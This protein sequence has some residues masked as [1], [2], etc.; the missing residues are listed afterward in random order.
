MVAFGFDELG[1]HRLV[2][3]VH[4]DNLASLRVLMRVGMQREGVL[5]QDALIEGEWWD[6]VYCSLLAS[7]RQ[8]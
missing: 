3:V 5:R 7:E 2:A 6:V 4:P 1:L 8:R